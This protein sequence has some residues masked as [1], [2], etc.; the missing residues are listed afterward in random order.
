MYLPHISLIEAIRVH[1][2]RS[3]SGGYYCVCSAPFQGQHCEYKDRTDTL[4]TVIGLFY[5]HV[6]EKDRPQR[7]LIALRNAG[8][9]IQELE[10]EAPDYYLYAVLL[11]DPNTSGTLRYTNNLRIIAQQDAG[12]RNFD[13]VPAVAAYYLIAVDRTI[14]TRSES[15]FELRIVESGAQRV[16]VFRWRFAYNTF[17]SANEQRSCSPVIE[18]E[19]WYAG[20]D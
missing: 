10:V 9:T 16:D 11:N 2:C 4:A 15:H 13:L 14:V 5:D 1:V 12:L 3:I 18:M 17:T 19:Q 8:N 20:N 6:I 7:L